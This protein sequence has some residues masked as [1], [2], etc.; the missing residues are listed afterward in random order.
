MGFLDRIYRNNDVDKLLNPTDIFGGRESGL[1]DDPDLL[2]SEEELESAYLTASSSWGADLL[3]DLDNPVNIPDGALEVEEPILVDGQVGGDFPDE[4]TLLPSFTSEGG[5]I[6]GY[7]PQDNDDLGELDLSDPDITLGGSLTR[8]ELHYF[9]LIDSARSAV[10]GGDHLSGTHYA[11]QAVCVDLI[12]GLGRGHLLSLDGIFTW[13]DDLDNIEDSLT[14]IF[15]GHN[16]YN[17]A[18]SLSEIGERNSPESESYDALV[19][20]TDFNTDLGAALEI[21]MLRGLGFDSDLAKVRA[22]YTDLSTKLFSGDNSNIP[23]IYRPAFV[24]VHNGLGP[25]LSALV[26][27]ARQTRE[28]LPELDDDTEEVTAELYKRPSNP[29][30]R[31]QL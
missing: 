20:G 10:E 17:L 2:P 3:A 24:K 30:P 11:A 23:S 22:A 6:I 5:E 21:K 13:G 19:T 29:Q 31:A 12:Y 15:N 16:P 14:P 28:L 8:E 18:R 7:A 9:S 27:S 26:H 1:E 25:V 4:D